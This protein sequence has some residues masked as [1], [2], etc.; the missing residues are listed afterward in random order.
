MSN[1]L[2]ITLDAIVERLENAGS[3]VDLLQPGLSEDSA[4]AEAKSL[5]FELPNALRALYGW[6]NGTREGDRRWCEFHPGFTLLSLQD[7][8]V[9]YQSQHKAGPR[10][11]KTWLPILSNDGG[12]Y[13]LVDCTLPDLTPV[14]N[15]KFDG[16]PK[17][18]HGSLLAYAK[19][20]LSCYNEGIFTVDADGFVDADFD[21]WWVHARKLNPDAAKWQADDSV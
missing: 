10:W 5:P 18:S 16:D 11:P 21:K 19:T 13:E 14:I 2:I 12:D 15:S 17:A 20:T 9:H 8:V 4:R 1:E 6:R 7:A 3:A